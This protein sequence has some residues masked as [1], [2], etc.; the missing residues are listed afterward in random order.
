MRKIFVLV[1]AL[2]VV[3]VCMFVGGSNASSLLN[4]SIHKTTGG[5]PDTGIDSTRVVAYWRN[6]TMTWLCNAT[7]T[8]SFD[9]VV[10]V[11]SLAYYTYVA[12]LYD[13][14]LQIAEMSDHG[15]SIPYTGLWPLTA[16]S[17]SVV[18]CAGTNARR[19]FWSDTTSIGSGASQSKTLKYRQL[20]FTKVGGV[21][22]DA[23]PAVI[24]SVSFVG[25]SVEVT[26]VDSLPFALA[27]NDSFYF[28]GLYSPPLVTVNEMAD[29]VWYKDSTTAMF[30]SPNMALVASRTG[31]TASLD[32]TQVSRYVWNTPFANVNDKAGSIGDSLS[33]ETWMGGSGGSGGLTTEEHDSLASLWATSGDGGIPRRGELAT[34]SSAAETFWN[35][36]FSFAYDAGSMAD[37]FKSTTWMGGSASAT[38]DSLGIRRW[39][40]SDSSSW[41]GDYK[42][43]AD[44]VYGS[45]PAEAVVDEEAIADAVFNRDVSVYSTNDSTFGYRASQIDLSYDMLASGVYGLAAIKAY[46]DVL[47]GALPE[48]WDDTYMDKIR[49]SVT[50][51]AARLTVG[52]ATALDSMTWLAWNDTLAAAFAARVADSVL[53]TTDTADTSALWMKWLAGVIRDSVAMDSNA[54]QGSAA[55]LSADEIVTA[56]FAKDISSY[57]TNDSSFGYRVNVQLD[58]VKRM[59]DSVYTI[60]LKL[61]D[62]IDMQLTDVTGGSGGL[63]AAQNDSLNAIVSRLRSVQAAVGLSAVKVIYVDDGGTNSAGTNWTNARTTIRQGV[64][65]CTG[66]QEYYVFVAPGT[67]SNTR[68]SIA[69]SNIHIVGAGRGLTKVDGSKD[70]TGI[71]V[72]PV[73]SGLEIAGMT[74]DCDSVKSYVVYA[75]DDLKIRDCKI[76]GYVRLSGGLQTVVLEMGSSRRGCQ[77]TDNVFDIWSPVT[78]VLDCSGIGAEIKG[79]QFYGEYLYGVLFEGTDRGVVYGNLFNGHGIAMQAD[80]TSD[81]NIVASNFIA[82]DS[83]TLFEDAGEKNVFVG[84]QKA[85]EFS[86]L[87]TMQE[88]LER[89]KD[90]VSLG[91]TTT[92]MA[93]LSMQVRDSVWKALHSSYATDTGSF[94]YF[95]D[96][97]IPP[98]ALSA[99]QEDTLNMLVSNQKILL[100]LLG[101]YGA[102]I[103]YVD[104]TGSDDSTGLSWTTARKTIT[105]AVAALTGAQQYVVFV[106]NGVYDEE[107]VALTTSRVKIIGR[108]VGRTVVRGGTDNSYVF[109]VTGSGCLLSGMTVYADSVNTAAIGF[110]GDENEIS[111]C[112]FYGEPLVLTTPCTYVNVATGADGNRIL[113]NRF[114]AAGSEAITIAE[115]ARYSEIVGNTISG[116][117]T[118]NVIDIG[119]AS[120]TKLEDNVVMNYD[121]S[122]GIVYLRSGADSTI[123]AGNKFGQSVA[124]SVLDSTAAN[125]TVALV[126]N[127]ESFER[128]VNDAVLQFSPE[129]YLWNA[130][131]LTDVMNDSVLNAIE[132]A[133]KA[134]FKA[135]GF[136]T[137][138]QGDSLTNAIADAN[139]ANFKAT[140]F[141]TS[142][143]GDSLTNAIADAN[144]ANFKA[145]GFATSTQGDSLTNAIADANKVNLGRWTAAQLDSVLN[146]IEDANKAN[147]KA[148]GFATST[149]GDSLT[150][151]ITDVNKVNF[152]TWISDEKDSVLNAIEDANK[153]NFKAT[154]FATSTQGDSLT[155][156]IADANKANFKATGFATSAQ[157][158]SLTNAV[159]DVNKANF[160][161]TGFA[162]S[163][164]GDSLTNAIADANKPNF[165]KWSSAEKDSVLNAI[166]DLN[167]VN[168]GRW[169]AAQLD[170]ILNAID[171]ANKANF[172]AT[173]FATVEDV[174]TLTDTLKARF[175]HAAL[176]DDSIKDTLTYYLEWLYGEVDTIRD[177]VSTWLDAS[178]SSRY[179]DTDTVALNYDSLL[180]LLWGY[181]TTNF[182]A[183]DMGR[184]V[185][186]GGLG[187]SGSGTFEAA[188]RAHLDTLL[189]RVLLL[190]A[191]DSSYMY[192]TE[193][194]ELAA[195]LTDSIRELAGLFGHHARDSVKLDSTAF[196]GSASGLTAVEIRDSVWKAYQYTYAADTGTMGYFLDTMM[197]ALLGLTG[198]NSVNLVVYDSSTD[199][200]VSG[201]GVLLTTLSGENIGW[202]QS[203]STGLAAFVMASNDTVLAYP[204]AVFYTFPSSPDTIVIGTSTVRDTLYGYRYAPTVSSDSDVCIVWGYVQSL[205][206]TGSSGSIVEAT[207]D[208]PFAV[209]YGQVLLNRWKVADTTGVDGLWQLPVFVSS[210]LTPSTTMTTFIAR[211]ANGN[212][213]GKKSV[214][215][216]DSSTYYMQW[217]N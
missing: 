53:Q 63:S 200:G 205:S 188:D 11:D 182:A 104:S 114:E 43:N 75:G 62:S 30:S 178:I 74:I 131:S 66:Y 19:Q 34:D 129:W 69:T 116:S 140:G 190:S 21:A 8:G 155:N 73:A 79:N 83:T 87:F 106:G 107:N 39:V 94:G 59:M 22:V 29:S 15:W 24:Y 153:A 174:D 203:K 149:Q 31:G 81:S 196:Q 173:G 159:R 125:E 37:S 10:A 42:K 176:V 187:G 117:Y 185:I 115:N 210:K 111:D 56:L 113:R 160:K 82:S 57:T 6:S 12:K 60:V 18:L 85:S 206:G 146:A 120:Y 158:D 89:V 103:Y 143:Q 110:A 181:D 61:R 46:V 168:L 212:S 17:Q 9:T 101:A 20:L 208:V 121:T 127:N 100:S 97:L 197:T 164:Q 23:L 189:A 14:G 165:M 55:G 33:S 151:A 170:S 157:G 141:A 2:I 16:R 179:A 27:A 126:G 52:R 28:S 147:F 209:R 77:I 128:Y 216:P 47:P 134:N 177:T 204:S 122:A 86:S 132:D 171:D 102:K 142:T 154:G 13:A 95:L 195:V 186:D 54:F 51:V 166:E 35:K 84:N 144:K 217:G 58:S 130:D 162:T 145:T 99:A 161:A 7:G 98:S 65:D 183:T 194:R 48:S 26:V 25:D 152:G 93:T 150:N 3:T 41:Y 50:N 1:T 193:K 71:F 5:M 67:Y 136:A 76:Y 92:N 91:L 172:K 68:V 38:I 213:L 175:D 49:D 109:N 148:T 40:W 118:T 184:F 135:T 70:S 214:I 167:K 88:D 202:R 156:A 163:T 108:G 215:V 133:N 123:V 4:L 124:V 192:W 112:A 105:N 36:P 44:T 198:L 191:D 45:P 72:A 169:T 96:T 201:A 78:S 207:I 138:A 64:M 32:S 90:S 180:T 139:K 211:N 137:S 80:A 119:D 199:A